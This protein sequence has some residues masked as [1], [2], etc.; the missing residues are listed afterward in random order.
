MMKELYGKA[1]IHTENLP[2]PGRHSP[3]MHYRSVAT[4]LPYGYY[5]KHHDETRPSS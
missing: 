4:Q 3:P 2:K 5:M 1:S